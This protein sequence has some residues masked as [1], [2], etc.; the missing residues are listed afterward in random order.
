MKR[1]EFRLQPALNHRQRLEDQ[2]RVELAELAS[3]SFR[4][5]TEIDRLESTLAQ[6]LT[7]AR[8]ETRVDLDAAQRRADYLVV[9]DLDLRYR[10]RELE[11]LESA[12]ELKRQEVLQASQDR[13]AL[14]KVREQ[15]KDEHQKAV[16]RE[17]QR[18]LDDLRVSPANAPA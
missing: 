14:E 1:F 18:A 12:M 7:Q 6:V 3:E 5:T 9:L 11:D 16:L 15:R 10:R 13:R 8:H 17:E 4:V 2:R